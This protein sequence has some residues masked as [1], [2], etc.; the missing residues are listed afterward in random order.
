MGDDATAAAV[1]PPE[2][3][4]EITRPEGVPR[5][6]CPIERC[7]TG[8]KLNIVYNTL[9]AL[10]NFVCEGGAQRPHPWMATVH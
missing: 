8:A 3:I 9:F 5:G 10:S 4:S 2:W 7:R 6:G 1:G